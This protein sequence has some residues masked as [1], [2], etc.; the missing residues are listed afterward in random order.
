[1]EVDMVAIASGGLVGRISRVGFNYSVVTILLEDNFAI[2]AQS[3]RTQAEG[4]VRGDIN[5][6][7]HGLL[8]M[9]RIN[10]MADIVEGDIIHTSHISSIF[11]PGIRIGV[12]QEI[13]RSSTGEI[14]AIIDPS[15]DFSS[16]SIMFIIVEVN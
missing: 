3:Q 7:S 8:R 2:A 14:Y 12:V 1:M 15:V 16:L 5:L 11:P 13:G 10:P 9:T 6:S 4:V